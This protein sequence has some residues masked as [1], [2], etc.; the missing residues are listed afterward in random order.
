QGDNQ[1][2]G[3]TNRIDVARI[4]V[5]ALTDPAARNVTVEVVKDASQPVVPPD[6][7]IFAGLKV[8]VP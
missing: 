3:Q 4:C 5:R 2:P 1:G 8:D 7:D 6:G